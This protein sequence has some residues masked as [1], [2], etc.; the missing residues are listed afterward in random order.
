MV[1]ITFQTEGFGYKNE[2]RGRNV[3]NFVKIQLHSWIY[4][5]ISMDS[6]MWILLTAVRYLLRFLKRDYG[7][8]SWVVEEF[9]DGFQKVNL[10]I[11]NDIFCPLY[12]SQNLFSQ[13]SKNLSSQWQWNQVGVQRKAKVGLTWRVIQWPDTDQLWSSAR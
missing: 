7:D 2:K 12:T 3:E 5:V 10:L 8:A 4:V 13:Y 1:I 6:W 9:N 11:M